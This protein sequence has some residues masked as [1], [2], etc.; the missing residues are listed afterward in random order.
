MFR[1][2]IRLAMMLLSCVFVAA[3]AHAQSNESSYRLGP[4]DKLQ[5]NVFGHKDLSGEFEVDGSGSVSVP[6][7]GEVK[8]GGTTLRQFEDAVV[9]KLKPDYLKNPKVSVQ[10]L[11]YRPFYILGEVKKPGSYPFVSGMKVI[12]AV[13]LAGGYTYRAKEGQL[14]VIHANDPERKKR[15]ADHQT[16]VLPGDVLEVPER[17]F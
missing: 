5:I 12:N 13:A 3:A 7:V 14:F 11:N 15:P 6:L 2:L 9:A 16:P 8:A 10:V 1:R 17:F 4:G